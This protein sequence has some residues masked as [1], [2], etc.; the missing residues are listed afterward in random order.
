MSN[1]SVA[2]AY[3]TYSTQTGITN[4]VMRVGAV[5]LSK[6]CWSSFRIV[7]SKAVAG[8]FRLCFC[9]FICGVCLSSFVP[10]LSFF[11][12]L[13]LNVLPDLGISWVSSLIH[14]LN[15]ASYKY[16]HEHTHTH[17]IARTHA[18]ARGI[19]SRIK[20]LFIIYFKRQV[21]YSYFVAVWS[22]A[23]TIA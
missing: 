6:L 3:C 17:T 2:Y 12:C 22:I 9:S 20:S 5:S 10:H 8:L 13:G 4:S 18:R 16:K 21:V 7:R 11:W 14:C 1:L 19:R 23:K 15:Y